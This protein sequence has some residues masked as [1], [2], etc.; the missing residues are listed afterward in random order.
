MRT[1][2]GHAAQRLFPQRLQRQVV[3]VVVQ[4]PLPVLDPVEAGAAHALPLGGELRLLGIEPV[5][6]Q[7]HADP[8]AERGHVDHAG[9]LGAEHE[10]KARRAYRRRFRPPAGGVVIGQRDDVKTGHLRPGDDR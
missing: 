8:P 4:Q 1:P 5:R 10:R 9:Q 2:D 3:A 6:Q 7:V